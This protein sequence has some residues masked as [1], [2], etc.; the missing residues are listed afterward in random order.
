[1]ER[2]AE[3]NLH[4]DSCFSQLFPHESA[5]TPLTPAQWSYFELTSGYLKYGLCL[6]AAPHHPKACGR[7]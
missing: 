3:I 1:M 7:L 2:S 6:W 4:L 5:T